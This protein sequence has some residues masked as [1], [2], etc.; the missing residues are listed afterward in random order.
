MIG[1]ETKTVFAA[2]EDTA[3]RHPERGFLNV[4]PETAGIY[5]IAAGEVSYAE[6]AREVAA[7][8]KR[9][10]AAGY[11]PGQRVMLLMENRPAFFLWWLALNG[12][13]LSVVPVNPDLRA[14]E[15]SYMIDHAEPVLAV[16]IPARGDDLR[17]A[18]RQAG[19]DMPVIAPEDSLPAP[20]TREAIAARQGGAEEAEAALL[21][22]S[23]TTGQP[24]GC[25]L[26]NAYFLD[27]G[28]WYA[29]T[30]GLCALSQDGERMIT[31]LPIFHMNAMAYSFM[32]MIAVGGCLTALDRFHPRSWWAS[33]RAS[34]ATCLHYLGV[35]PSMLM[36][37]E[38]SEADRDHAVRFGFGA[39]V[40]PKLHA[41]FEARFGFP[42]VEAWAM[43]ETGAGAVICANREPRRVGESCLGTPEGG[44]EVRLLNDAGQEADQGELLVRRAGAEPRRGFFVGYFKN[45]EATDEA[46]AGG[47]FHTGDI[48]RRAPDG[49]MYFVDRKKNVIRRSGE[50]IAA[51]EVESTLMRH[52]AVASAAVAAVPD[53]VRGDEVFACIVPKDAGADPAVLAREITEWSLTQLAYYKAPGFIAFVEALPL[54]ATQ[55]L[56]RG[57]L[58]T[59]AADLLDDPATQDLR[60]LKKRTAA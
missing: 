8:R 38:E 30:G 51:V 39:G 45:A 11:L 32:A 40:D 48:V 22:T 35:M 52:P 6:A 37:A 17:A 7:L 44:L 36:G 31:P 34:G 29:D 20:A 9:I 21:Y 4:L 60:G 15:L 14:A 23:G 18:A 16:A 19:R 12:L 26:T 10:S 24:K 42:L 27:A 13:G 53:A 3:A 46:W 55:K 33:V 49:A 2:F 1:A 5:G 47:W 59:L 28:R 58:K 50:N 43:T 57:V 56:Q 54:T 25:I 41:A